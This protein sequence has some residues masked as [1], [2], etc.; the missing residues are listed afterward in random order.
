MSEEKFSSPP[1]S[2]PKPNTTSD[3]GLPDSSRNS[4]WRSRT[5]SAATFSAASSACSAM[6]LLPASVSSTLS[7]PCTSRQTRRVDCAARQRRNCPGHC[8]S[9]SSSNGGGASAGWSSVANRRG[10]DTSVS[11]AKSLASASRDKRSTCSGSL[12]SEGST[13]CRRA[14]ARCTI[15]SSDSVVVGDMAGFWHGARSHPDHKKKSPQRFSSCGPSCPPPNWKRRHRGGVATRV[16]VAVQQLTRLKESA[17]SP[18]PGR[19]PC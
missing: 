14:S 10:C 1:P 18:G 13:R 6:R 11:I 17:R 15:D 8:A 5:C 3:C 16:H 9:C 19:C 2:F 12:P 7:R 4:P